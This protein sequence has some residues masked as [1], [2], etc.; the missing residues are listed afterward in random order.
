MKYEGKNSVKRECT[1]YL[2]FVPKISTSI[3]QHSVVILGICLI[4]IPL[5]K[6]KSSVP[7]TAREALWAFLQSRGILTT[8]S[9]VL[10]A[11]ELKTQEE[12]TYKKRYTKKIAA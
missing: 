1:A 6:Q 5:L 12:N 7:L 2:I 10:E 4:Q 11:Q 3:L 9:V 8:A